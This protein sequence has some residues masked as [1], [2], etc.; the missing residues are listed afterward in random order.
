MGVM[1]GRRATGELIEVLVDDEGR[2]IVTVYDYE[3]V[4]GDT[5]VKGESGFLH[6]VTVN[7]CTTA[8]NLTIYDND[9]EA[10]DVIAVIVLPLNPAPFTL[11][12][13]I[14]FANGLYLGFDGVLVADITVSY[15]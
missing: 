1:F 5:E 2:I 13:D 3:H 8:G 10:G 6:T 4:I 11:T 7:A 9:V 12:Y 14:E 15:E